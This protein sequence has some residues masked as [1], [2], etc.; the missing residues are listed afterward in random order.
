MN[1]TPQ[2]QMS[3]KEWLASAFL[4]IAFIIQ[5]LL[6]VLAY[7]SLNRKI[8]LSLGWI[9]LACSLIVFLSS[10]ILQKKGGIPEGKHYAQTSQL[11][12]S[13]IYG[14][15]RHPIY[16]SVILLSLGLAGISQ[17]WVSALASVPIIIAMYWWMVLEEKMTL[18]RLGEAYET[19][20]QQVPRINLLLGIYR[21]IRRGS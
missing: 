17:H 1:D 5:L 19:Y 20:M 12:D 2:Y 15:I 10:N 8:I 16:F 18:V 4:G 14:V 21:R 3:R 11:V 9:L 7:N 6:S 13:G